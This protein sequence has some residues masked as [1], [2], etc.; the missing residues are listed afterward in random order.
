MDKR[1][2]EYFE[3]LINEY[4]EGRAKIRGHHPPEIKEAIDTFFKACQMITEHPEIESIPTEYV[5]KLIAAFAQHPQYHSL[6]LD[7]IGI[8]SLDLDKLKDN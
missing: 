4:K 2:K 6:V 7:I 8:L 1:S 3:F 5:E